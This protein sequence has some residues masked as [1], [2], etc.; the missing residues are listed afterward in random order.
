VI[1]RFDLADAIRRRILSPFNYHAL[2]YIP[3][4]DDRY[5]LQQVYVRAAARE[6]SGNPMTQEEIWI[7]LAKVY[8]TSRTK[9]PIFRNFIREHPEL[10][11]RC[12]IFVETREY[13]EEVLEIVHSHRHDFHTYYAAEDS[14]TLQR[15]ASGELECLVTCH[16]LSEGIDIQSLRNVILFSSARARLE[17][18]Q[19]MGRCLRWDPRNPG[20]RANVV[21]FVRTSDPEAEDINADEER[22][23]WLEALSRIS[24]GGDL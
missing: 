23:D 8:K 20:K 16:R 24:P 14:T 17:T 2:S 7:E 5:R 9:L 6:Q 12:I 10:L 22:R 4:D 18:I 15:F 19:R 13:G 21:D 11:A 1:F 3:D